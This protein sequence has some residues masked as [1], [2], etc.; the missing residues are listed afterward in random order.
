VSVA[1]KVTLGEIAELID[2]GVTAS[3]TLQP[4][5]HKFLRITDIQNGSVDW[6]AVPWCQCTDEQA[7][8]SRLSPGDIVFARTGATTGKN[9]L[10]RHCP[11]ES[12]F[13]SY[14]IR[15][16]LGERA[17]PRYVSH[18]FQTPEYWS[19]VTSRSRGVA[20]LG[21]NATTLRGISLPLPQLEEQRRIAA[22]LDQAEALRAK[23]RAAL[24]KL[25]LLTK[26]LY[27][28]RFGD[29]LLGSG[30]WQR[31]R[32]ADIGR[33]ITDNTPSRASDDFFGSEIEW[34]KSDNLGGPSC[35]PTRAHEGLS[36]KGKVV[37]RVV[38]PG[39]ILVTCIAGSPHS[40]GDVNRP[41]FPRDSTL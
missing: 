40:I 5:R 2:Y 34:I 33:V 35:F 29:P 7:S 23:G 1:A 30:K 37:A 17:E 24:E 6:D 10:I 9:F 39:S 26:S 13:A 8:K 32:I 25:N 12:V 15:L 16:R 36:L 41:G 28:E 22:I 21:V 20:Q 38:P 27:I 31:R 4:G 14:L 18:F 19:Q 11:T 3:A